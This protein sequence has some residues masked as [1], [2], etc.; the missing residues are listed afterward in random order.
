MPEDAQDAEDAEAAVPTGRIFSRY[1]V[2]SA[3][4]GLICV[5]A[6]AVLTLIWVH[7]RDDVAERTHQTN[8]MQAAVD[9]TGV[10][11]VLGRGVRRRRVILRGDGSG[12]QCRRHVLLFGR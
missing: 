9:W 7:H 8:A 2:A 12:G 5:A 10:G 11:Q 6:A 3:L 1:G 4:L